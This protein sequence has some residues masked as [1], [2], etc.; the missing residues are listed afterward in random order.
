MCNELPLFGAV[1]R[2]EE[3][4]GRWLSLAV[5]SLAPE[6][7]PLQRVRLA[8]IDPAIQI[9]ESNLFQEKPE[10]LRGRDRGARPP[11][12]QSSGKRNS[13][14]RKPTPLHDRSVCSGR[15]QGEQE[16]V[17]VFLE[18]AQNGIRIPI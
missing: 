16:N 18:T 3:R 5:S 12:W 11:A 4:G 15:M 1:Q 2:L 9:E 7:K 8:R 6:E 17:A 10:R 13:Q 14:C